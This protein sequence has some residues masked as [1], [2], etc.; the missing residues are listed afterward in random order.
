MVSLTPDPLLF[1][2]HFLGLYSLETGG[3]VVDT[4]GIR[5]FGLSGLRRHEL[6]SFYPEISALAPRCRFN[7]CAHF[8]EPGCAVRS[9]KEDGTV[10]SSRYN[11]YRVIR[12]TLPE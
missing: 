5:E 8:E 2:H 7:N 9:G 1:L 12:E 11:T 6:V 10:P 3:F 4:P